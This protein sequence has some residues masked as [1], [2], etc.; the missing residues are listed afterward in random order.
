MSD[1]SN[2]YKRMEVE[3]G[4]RKSLKGHL[5]GK[6][7]HI[8]LV[9]MAT[10]I[11]ILFVMVFVIFG[12]QERRFAAME[13]FILR[14]NSSLTSVNSEL[15]G[16]LQDT[17][18]ELEK[19]VSE[20]KKSV[21]GLSSYV[22][23]YTS[24]IQ[25]Q[26][27]SG[28]QVKKITTIQTLINNLGSSLGSL[29]SKLETQLQNTAG[30]QSGQ[31]TELKGFLDRLNSSVSALAAKL[32]DTVKQQDMGVV[33]SSLASLNSSLASF[34]SKQLKQ[35][36][37]SDQRVMAALNEIKAKLESRDKDADSENRTLVEVAKL[38]SSVG[39]LSSQL[40]ST[41][42]K[43]VTALNDIKAKLE[44]KD[45][46]AAVLSCKSGWMMFG[47]RCYLF[48]NDKLSWHQARDY[49][50]SHNSFLLTLESDAEW[51][52]VTSKTT[53]FHFW[54]GLTDELTGQWRWDDGTPY[55]MNKDQWEP[56][57]PDDWRNHGL[58]EEGEDCAHLKKEGK[59][60]DAHCSYKINYIC[61]TNARMT[62][63]D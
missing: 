38:T 8:L 1:P 48:S 39:S 62:D 35:T 53:K 13:S 26:F 54:V 55:V 43:V 31:Y 50:R 40:Q 18:S 14:H 29:S 3:E 34:E 11:F 24:R 9:S 57:Q 49:C 2:N 56:G 36:Q 4:W 59:L 6:Q 33:G 45:K 44:S 63:H 51:A 42:Q 16:K 28:T 37:D 15:K 22:D 47:F 21:S 61:R 23:M 17:G 60:N 20:L 19:M 41:D 32:Q 5:Q 12:Y 30:Q 7:R 46:P 10:V 58:G 25:T 27:D 52:F